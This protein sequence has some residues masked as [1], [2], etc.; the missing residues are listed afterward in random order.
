MKNDLRVLSTRL[1]SVALLLGAAIP[2]QAGARGVADDAKAA[3]AAARVATAAP[4]LPKKSIGDCKDAP[5]GDKVQDSAQSAAIA[6]AAG[7]LPATGGKAG[8]GGSAMGAA[9]SKMGGLNIGP[10]AAKGALAG[11][12]VGRDKTGAAAIKQLETAV[13]KKPAAAQ[14]DTRSPCAKIAS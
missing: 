3:L 14:A 10:S 1:L 9:A 13:Q 7:R 5:V 4:T 11:G 6:A 2:M 8:I 12:I